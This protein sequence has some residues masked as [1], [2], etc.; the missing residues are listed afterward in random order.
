MNY[1]L[2]YTGNANPDLTKVTAT[3]DLH[4]AQIVDRSLL[5]KATLIQVD[6]SKLKLLQGNLDEDWEIFPEK[7]YQVPGSKKKIRK[8]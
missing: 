6:E 8:S 5:P 4:G 1:I 3:L 2:R 7:I